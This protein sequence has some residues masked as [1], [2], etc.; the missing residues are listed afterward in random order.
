MFI[1][2]AGLGCSMQIIVTAVQNAVDRRDM[3]TATS[4]VTFFRMMGGTFGTA[5]FGA[6]LTSRLATHL[7]EQFATLGGSGASAQVPT[8]NISDN[9]QTIKALPEPIHGLVLNG[10]AATLDDVFLWAVPV[11]LVALAVAFFIKEVP[12]KSR[13][14][15]SEDEPAPE[16]IALTH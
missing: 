1:F 9:V 12:L 15:A 14:A 16:E 7:A 2:G 11:V 13:E 10:F 6:I 3:G 5:V 8:G 4:A